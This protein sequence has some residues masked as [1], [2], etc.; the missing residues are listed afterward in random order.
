MTSRVARPSQASTSIVVTDG[1]E[2]ERVDALP[3][4]AS[5]AGWRAEGG[6]GHGG[7]LGGDGVSCRI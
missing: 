4:T 6:V 3:R 1:S 7:T 5:Q 2:V